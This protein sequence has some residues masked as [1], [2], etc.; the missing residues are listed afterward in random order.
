MNTFIKNLLLV[1]ILLLG[2]TG[3]GIYWT[4]YRTLPNYEATHTLQGLNEE[5]EIHWDSYGVPHIYAKN[6]DDLYYSLGYVHAQD[7]LWQMTLTQMASE[8]RLAEFLGKDLIQADLFQRTLG[9]WE[10][11]KQMEARLPDSTRRI[12]QRYTDGV[13]SYVQQHPN[14]LPLEYTL[15]DMEPIPWTVTHSLALARMIAWELNI[16]WKNELSL[17]YLSQHLS[18][19]QFQE[20]LPNNEFLTSAGKNNLKADPK[21]TRHVAGRPCTQK[22]VKS[23]RI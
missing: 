14:Q 8:G 16:A 1:L 18:Q 4:F 11:A 7:R 13:N 22:S 17:A 19:Q 20:L 15:V 3:L 5:V 9:F 10:T 2:I 6:K 12:L 23:G 21:N